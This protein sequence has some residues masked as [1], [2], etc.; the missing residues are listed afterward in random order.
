MYSV[1]VEHGIMPQYYLVPPL[2]T[3]QKRVLSLKKILVPISSGYKADPKLSPHYIWL[4][5]LALLVIVD[6]ATTTGNIHG[7]SNTCIHYC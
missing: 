3:K 5:T 7:V 6:R 2:D 1:G 4:V